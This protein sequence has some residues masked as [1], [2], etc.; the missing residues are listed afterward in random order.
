MCTV[1]TEKKNVHY[2]SSIFMNMG[3][4]TIMGLM[5]DSSQKLNNVK[6]TSGWKIGKHFGNKGL[7]RFIFMGL[8]K[9][10]N[11]YIKSPFLAFVLVKHTFFICFKFCLLIFVFLLFRFFPKSSSW[12]S[13]IYFSFFNFTISLF[14]TVIHYQL[15]SILIIININN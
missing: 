5:I 12:Y 1:H 11:I 2:L 3:N 9:R 10:K 7:K 15:I 4:I 6:H 8:M 13:I 14:I